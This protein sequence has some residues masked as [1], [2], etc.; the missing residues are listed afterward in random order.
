MGKTLLAHAVAGEAGV[1]F[2]SIS[3]WK[4][5]EMF[6][7]VGVG[8]ARVA[9]TV[10]FWWIDQIARGGCRSWRCPAKACLIVFAHR[11]K[12]WGS[13]DHSAMHTISGLRV[14]RTS[15]VPS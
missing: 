4:F 14:C 5:V 13:N 10:R 2:Y 12:K 15:I 7:G 8:A 11:C 6:V 3:G 9:L 1:P